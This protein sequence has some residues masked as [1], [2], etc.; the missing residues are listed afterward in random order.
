[1]SRN[2]S[3][4]NTLLILLV[5]IGGW[6]ILATQAPHGWWHAIPSLVFLLGMPGYLIWRSMVVKP[7]KVS[8][9]A[10]RL[11]Y[12]VGL[13]LFTLM[14][15]G[16]ILNE[17][18]TFLGLNRPLSVIPLTVMVAGVCTLLAVFA[19]WRNPQSFHAKLPKPKV[20]RKLPGIVSCLLLPV[21][22]AAGAVTLNNGGTAGLAL[23]TFAGIAG[24]F[25]V[26]V[27]RDRDITNLYPWFLFSAGLSLLIGTSLR[28]WNI[29][30]HDVMQ[31]YQVFQL[32]LQHA[33]WHMSYY[34]DAYTACL[35]I[36]I[37]PTMLQRLTSISDQYIY[38]FV[39]Q[40]FFA[41]IGPVLYE[42]MRTFTSKRL[43]LLATFLFITFPTF[44]TD[45]MMLNR[46]E[47]AFLFLGLA[48]LA[49]TDK[50]LNRHVKSLFI[51]LFLIGMVL[52]HYST[53]YEATGTFIFAILLGLIWR[54][55]MRRKAPKSTPPTRSL[56]NIFSLPVILATFVV[57]V[58]WGSIATQTSTNIDQTF[59][60]LSKGI[61][62]RLDGSSSNSPSPSLDQFATSSKQA[63]SLPPT[64]FY[65]P[66][67]TAAYPLQAT[68]AP[69]QA[70]TT[71]AIHIGLKSNLLSTFYG[72]IRS[73]YEGVIALAIPAG[74]I[75]LLWCRKRYRIP[76][77]YTLLAGGAFSMVVIQMAFPEA[78][79]YGLAR[80][81]QQA[82][83][84]AA[85][86][87][88]LVLI[89]GLKH[90][91]LSRQA[92]QKVVAL[93]LVSFFLVLS[94]FLPA[95]TGGSDPQLALSNNGLY[96][97]AY[98]THQ[99]EISAADWLKNDTPPGSQVSSDE[100]ARRKLI[101]YANIFSQPT[102][103]PT[104]IPTDSYVFLSYGDTEFN[105]VPVYDG[106]ALLYYRPPT[107]FL[108]A[109]KNEVYSSNNVQIYK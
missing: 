24:L 14:I 71:L 109:N 45:I 55:I 89:W 97:S 57:L 43:A 22:A 59:Q 104:A 50:R 17:A 11:S 29:T 49:S 32:T 85:L 61:T 5:I 16:L 67:D 73:S 51:L 15:S 69:K 95:L 47:T 31:E 76:L 58:G 62:S 78:V 92:A 56:V 88:I 13:S 36:T 77:Q 108:Q 90:L 87:I 12:I 83:L 21:F 34:Q 99:E 53:S 27:W 37:L 8:S 7:K 105:S 4:L 66:K 107:A 28:G 3:R 46:Q 80:A 72:L 79:N 9:K 60:A 2:H 18:Y 25:L 33:A 86:P 100:F 64:S 41:L 20:L 96:Y 42:T 98:Y 6:A 10:R 54:A 40:L 35:S 101:A 68:P 75:L 52:S 48:L 30:G 102:L 65:P 19:S 91:H 63:E 81:I 82:L 38:K 106:S 23:L 93:G 44:L 74:F 103:A 84:F 94:G 39:F 70:P 26:L 1:V